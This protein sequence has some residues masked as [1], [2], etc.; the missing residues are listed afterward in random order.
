MSRKFWAVHRE[1]G[2]RWK[3]VEAKKHFL[4]MYDSGYLA[5]VRNLDYSGM[6]ITPLD[7]AIWE[8]VYQEK[9]KC[10]G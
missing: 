9:E 5:E 4:V 10:H 1:T 6:H 7:P 3:P 8:T 2:Q